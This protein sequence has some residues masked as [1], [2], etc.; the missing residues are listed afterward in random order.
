MTT[1]A[2]LIILSVL[3]LGSLI[4]VSLVNRRQANAK[5][6]RQ[7]VKM[8][9]FRVDALEELALLLDH[10]VE[11]RLIVH[12]VYDEALILLDTM[13]KLDPDASYL[14]ATVAH[15]QRLCNEF[16]DTHGQRTI[17]RAMESDAKIARAK[18]ALAEAARILRQRQSLGKINSGDLDIFL[19][20]LA[21]N[22]VNVEVM[23]LIGRGLV[24]MKREDTLGAF[25]FYKKAQH[26][27]LQSNRR[28]EKRARLI[29]ELN[30]MQGKTR[31][32]PSY[33]L[34]PEAE[35]I[36]N[37]ASSTPIQEEPSEESPGPENTENIDEI[38]INPPIELD[39]KPSDQSASL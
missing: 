7:R 9:K 3:G 23:S 13:Q 21:C 34:M 4:A 16:A 28:D 36:M 11:S 14:K 1:L 37:A 39:S 30:E 12:H 15:A 8:L 33:D 32:L 27:L 38:N 2:S 25:A 20:D 29:K 35:P 19:N 17:N 26:A 5:R 24:A 6:A 31:L 18:Q 10:I 22:S